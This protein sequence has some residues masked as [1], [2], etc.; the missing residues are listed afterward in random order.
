MALPIHSPLSPSL[1]DAI[2]Q[3]STES[4]QYLFD[5]D[6]GLFANIRNPLI[7]GGTLIVSL[8][9]YGPNLAGTYS[10]QGRWNEAEQLEVQVMDMRKKLLGAEHPDALKKYGKSSRNIHS[11]FTHIR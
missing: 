9:T 8:A 3:V 10:S 7:T 1:P 2:M 5:S 4:E 6:S 11:P